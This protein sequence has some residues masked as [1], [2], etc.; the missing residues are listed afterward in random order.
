MTR[1]FVIKEG[2]RAHTE[3]QK[4]LREEALRVRGRRISALPL[5]TCDPQSEEERGRLET[6]LRHIGIDFKDLADAA[7]VDGKPYLYVVGVTDKSQQNPI[8]KLGGNAASE[9]EKSCGDVSMIAYWDTT[10]NT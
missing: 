2:S 8:N 10:G 9:N 4:R 7:E 6:R 5:V 3:A 1:P